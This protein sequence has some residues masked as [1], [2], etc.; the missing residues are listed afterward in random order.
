MIEFLGNIFRKG[1]LMCVCFLVVTMLSTVAVDAAC[2]GTTRYCGSSSTGCFSCTTPSCESCG[3]SYACYNTL[4]AC[5]S[6]WGTGS[7]T[8][9][10]NATPCVS[11]CVCGSYCHGDKFYENGTCYV[12][13]TGN[14]YTSTGCVVPATPLPT[15]AY[16]EGGGTSYVSATCYATYIA[17]PPPVLKSFIIIN[18]SGSEVVSEVGTSRNQIC[19]TRFNGVRLVT[20]E[21]GSSS[22]GTG[23]SISSVTLTWNGQTVPRLTNV[24]SLTTF[25]W[26][27]TS[28]IPSNLNDGSTHP[29]VVK[30]VDSVG[31]STVSS[32]RYFKIWDCKVPVSGTIYD[33]TSGVSCPNTGFSVTNA[34]AL[35]LKSLTFRQNSIGYMMSINTNKV[36]YYSDSSN[37]LIWSSDIAVPQFNEDISLTVP[38]LIRTLTSTGVSACSNNNYINTNIVDPYATSIGITADFTGS[39]AQDPWWQTN[40]GGVVSNTSISD[41]VPVTCVSNCQIGVSGLVSAPEINNTGKTS[42]Q[43]WSFTDAGAK[44]AN[45][46]TNYDYFYN[47]FLVKRGVGTVLNVGLTIN[48]INGLGSDSNGIYFINGDLTINGSIV[49][50]NNFLMVIVN[51]D[52]TVNQSASRVDGI[53]VANNIGA[54]GASSSQLVFNG[55][56][57]AFNNID[58]SRDYVNRV[59]NNTQ[60]AVVVRYD[61]KLIFNIPGNVAKVLTNWQWG[62]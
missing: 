57:F 34:S 6:V 9:D 17:N 45:S 14:V 24:G 10:C 47:Q 50:A 30:V 2:D 22:T 25:G 19:D 59:T 43:D 48:D 4:N 1:I 61:P 41:Q 31:S 32:P 26:T 54:S 12:C 23:T 38:F 35:N 16:C 13:S 49:N 42:Y 18:N 8:L 20:F 37:S 62:N 3:G 56:L 15:C 39:L 46:N 51:G 27:G 53:L 36:S 11:G 40:G 52:I 33:G 44:L 55:S 60:P 58:F 5:Q 29:L 7:G 28:V 21:V